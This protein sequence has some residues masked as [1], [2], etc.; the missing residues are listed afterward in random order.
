M[1]KRILNKILVK[2]NLKLVR[3]KNDFELF[4]PEIEFAHPS[5]INY[6]INHQSA[7]TKL[8]L[9][10]GRFLPIHSL[11]NKSNHPF[12]LAVRKARTSTNPKLS[13]HNTLEEFYKNYQPENA[14]I[15]LGLP[16]THFLATQPPWSII[17][18]WNTENPEQMTHR[19]KK[20]IKWE[21]KN[22]GRNI[23][24]EHGW[25][26]SGPVS[27]EK[28][29]IEVNRLYNI[30]ES[31]SKNGYLRSDNEHGDISAH[32]LMNDS[33]DWVWLAQY[34]LHRA[35]VVSGLDYDAIPVRVNRIIYRSDAAYWPNVLSGIYTL[36]EAK[37]VFDM[38][39]T[40]KYPIDSQ[41]WMML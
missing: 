23:N 41:K 36:K 2:R 16:G 37:N 6:F 5:S 27:K 34:G 18:P 15:V 21:N 1:I 25:N 29:A 26:W 28:L 38:I 39:F 13:I 3:I 10:K 17:L 30:Y 22:N 33:K 20:S 32:I 11:S 12:V 8:S 19:I 14:A 35:A 24:I 7:L 4:T 9:E 40:A 31:I